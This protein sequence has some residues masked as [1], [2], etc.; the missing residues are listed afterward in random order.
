MAGQEGFL[1]DMLEIS[2]PEPST[3]PRTRGIPKVYKSLLLLDL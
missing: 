2:T 3:S 1:G